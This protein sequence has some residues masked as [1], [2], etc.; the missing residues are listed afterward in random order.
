MR[1]LIG[2]YGFIAGLITAAIIALFGSNLIIGLVLIALGLLVGL[3]N[4]TSK[5]AITFLVSVIALI[6]S[7]N[8]MGDVL[9]SINGIVPFITEFLGSVT[10]FVAAAAVPVSF[11]GLFSTL[12]GR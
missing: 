10:L 9:G 2:R 8:A 1:N 4:V 6:V 5:E 7:M 12:K 11:S 3:M